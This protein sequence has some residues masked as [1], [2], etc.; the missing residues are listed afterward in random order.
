MEETTPGSNGD[1]VGISNGNEKC[2]GDSNDTN[3]DA[4]AN[5]CTS[6]T[7]IRT[8]CRGCALATAMAAVAAMATAMAVMTTATGAVAAMVKAVK[9]TIN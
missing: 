3:S 5:D 8:T 4:E 2:D 1:G 9:T 6:M 7:G